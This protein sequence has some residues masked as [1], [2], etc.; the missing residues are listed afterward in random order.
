MHVETFD[1]NAL[2]NIITYLFFKLIVLHYLIA[3]L[4]NNF[5][6]LLMRLQGKFYD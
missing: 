5:F 4:L 2:E 1:F 3:Q 6:Y